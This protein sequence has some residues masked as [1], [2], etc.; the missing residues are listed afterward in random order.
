MTQ[1]AEQRLFTEAWKQITEYGTSFTINDDGDVLCSY[2]DHEGRTCAF[3]PA[4]KDYD[5]GMEGNTA[6][7]LLENWKSHLQPWAL[8]LNSNFANAVQSCHDAAAEDDPNLSSAEQIEAFKINMRKLAKQW[9]KRK[10][11]VPR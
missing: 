11:K 3:G 8:K 9:P 5:P 6:R 4:I 10:L 1:S 2:K 7:T